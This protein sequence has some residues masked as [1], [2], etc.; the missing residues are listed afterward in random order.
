MSIERLKKGEKVFFAEIRPEEC[1]RELLGR[2]KEYFLIEPS[3]SRAYVAIVMYEK[4]MMPHPVIGIELIDHS[5]EKY[6]N[7]LP[8]IR[9][10]IND[11]LKLGDSIDTMLVVPGKATGY[12]IEKCKPFYS[13]D[14]MPSE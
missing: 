3:I 12:F 8:T 9:T 4:E 10:I 1:P 14:R 5:E 13:R 7:L 6:F 2:L 11:F